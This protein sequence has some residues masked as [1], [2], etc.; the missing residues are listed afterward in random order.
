MLKSDVVLRITA[1][2]HSEE[3]CDK[4]IK[5]VYE[6]IKGVLEEYIWRR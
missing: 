5:P 3:E 4:L 6:E 1:K 2:A